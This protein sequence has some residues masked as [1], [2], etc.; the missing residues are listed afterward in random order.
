M[1]DTPDSTGFEYR[2]DLNGDGLIDD[3]PDLAIF[4][5]DYSIGNCAYIPKIAILS[6]TFAGQNQ[7]A[8]PSTTVTERGDLIDV[9]VSVNSLSNLAGFEAV[10]RYDRA[11]LTLVSAE[12]RGQMHSAIRQGKGLY[13]VKDN[14]EGARIA[15]ALKNEGF[16]GQS[17][18]LAI[19]TFQRIGTSKPYIELSEL[20][21]ADGDRLVDRHRVNKE[22]DLNGGTLTT[23]LRQNWPNP[24]NPTTSIS[25]SIGERSEVSLVIYNA[26]GQE[27]RH[28]IFSKQIDPGE[29]KVIWDGK[30]DT[31]TPVS[32]GVYIYQL[33][34]GTTRD[35]RRMLFLK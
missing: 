1:D 23:G 15:V 20:Q 7:D 3:D 8:V 35:A 22:L 13:I 29:Y 33:I 10:I 4:T 28:L 9:S 18:E 31:G 6:S 16:L 14:D 30:S 12:P 2:Y 11:V 25:F 24:F 32:S 19:F 5:S 27:V 21:L 17:Q 26:L 34:A